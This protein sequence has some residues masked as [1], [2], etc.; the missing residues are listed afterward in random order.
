MLL[1]DD[2]LTF[3]RALLVAA[4]NLNLT[5]NCRENFKIQQKSRISTK[6]LQKLAPGTKYGRRVS[7]SN[8]DFVY[9]IDCQH[10]GFVLDANLKSGVKF[11]CLFS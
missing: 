4:Q 8:G 2:L 7:P 9:V 11:A 1:W 5:I 6:E 3:L 10:V